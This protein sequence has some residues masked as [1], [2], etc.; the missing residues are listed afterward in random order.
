MRLE[1]AKRLLR[2]S[3]LTVA[4]IASRTGYCNPAYLVNVFRDATGL[5]P[6]KWRNSGM[7]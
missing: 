7:Q 4:E 2:G 3:S 5:S 6:K 1:E